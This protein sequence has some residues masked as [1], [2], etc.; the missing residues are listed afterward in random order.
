MHTTTL[1]ALH[2]KSPSKHKS[3]VPVHTATGPVGGK[4]EYLEVIGGEVLQADEAHGLRSAG[5]ALEHSGALSAGR[6]AA[7]AAPPKQAQQLGSCAARVRARAAAHR[8]R[9]PALCRTLCK[10][11][12]YSKKDSFREKVGCRHARQGSEKLLGTFSR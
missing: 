11:L 4:P 7:A 9:G 1:H 6:Q 5:A 12:W 10:E 3:P 8:A 2:G